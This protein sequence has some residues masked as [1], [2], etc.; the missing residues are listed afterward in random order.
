MRQHEGRG[1]DRTQGTA[2]PHAA[3]IRADAFRAAAVVAAAAAQAI[4][5][6]LVPL[7]G[8]SREEVERNDPAISP[9]AFAHDVT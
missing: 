9:C 2:G 7:F 4:V 8:G 3:S 5:P 6:S 1:H